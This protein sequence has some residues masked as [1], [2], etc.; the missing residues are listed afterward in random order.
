MENYEGGDHLLCFSEV[1]VDYGTGTDAVHAIA[2]TSLCVERGTVLALIGASGCGKSTLL[3]L[4]LGM[5][6]PQKGSVAYDGLAL[7]DLDV[8]S[9]RRQIGVVMQNGQLLPGTIFSNI[10]GSL[11]LT[12]D[13]AWEAARL[14]GLAQDIKE[15]PMGMHTIVNDG[16]TVFS[17]GQ[18]QRLL[19][20]RSL[21]QRPRIVVFDEATS[22]LDNETQ[23][24]VTE[25]LAAMKATRILVAHRLSTIRHA[26]RI[27]VLENGVIAEEG[28]YEELMA[29][30]G[31]FFQLAE[32]Q[33]L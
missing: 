22:S 32:R 12:I 1:S 7:R 25:T 27:L 17:G 11:P 4:L 26:D 19:I 6:Q 24:I 23:A 16:G 33:Q 15:M 21:V 18:R 31:L 3:R 8:A 9:V 2:D 30:K 29:M 10:V 20:A 14:V 5:E 13:D 28:S